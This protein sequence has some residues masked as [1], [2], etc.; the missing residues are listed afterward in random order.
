MFF[1]QL[2]MLHYELLIYKSAVVLKALDVEL[3][4]VLLEMDL[5]LGLGLAMEMVLELDL[6]DMYYLIPDQLPKHMSNYLIK[7]SL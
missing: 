4:L 6:D 5:D 2:R 7:Q 3:V 1:D